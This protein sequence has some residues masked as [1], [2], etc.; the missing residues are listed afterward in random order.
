MAACSGAP[1]GTEEHPTGKDAG[2]S[3]ADAG[4]RDAGSKH[5]PEGGGDDVVVLAD[6]ADDAGDAGTPC[7]VDGEP[8]MCLNTSTCATMTDTVSMAGYCPGPADIECCVR[9]PNV[10]D[11]PPTPSG[12]ML[13]FKEA[14]TT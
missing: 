12:Y 10:A 5:T 14:V 4:R 1:S 9:T 3:A 11:N 7:S 8:G 6:A 13:L 2:V